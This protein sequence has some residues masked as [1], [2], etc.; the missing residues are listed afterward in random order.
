MSNFIPLPNINTNPYCEIHSDIALAIGCWCTRVGQRAL[1]DAGQQFQSSLSDYVLHILLHWHPRLCMAEALTH[2][3]HRTGLCYF[4]IL[5]LGGLVLWNRTPT[6]S[7]A[8]LWSSLHM[9]SLAWCWASPITRHQEFSHYFCT[10]W[11]SRDEITVWEVK[12]HCNN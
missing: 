6:A 11:T 4:Q 8:Q 10:N 3:G 1:L 5:V 12:K 7:E 2:A 9:W